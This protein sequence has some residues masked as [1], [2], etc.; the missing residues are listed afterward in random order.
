MESEPL[1]PDMT[2]AEAQKEAVTRSMYFKMIGKHLA[3]TAN[4]LAWGTY[5][6]FKFIPG[7]ADVYA[8]KF[9]VMHEYQ[10]GYPFLVVYMLYVTRQYLNINSSGARAAAA[11][12]RP[13]QHTYEDA[14]GKQV[15]MSSKGAKGRFNRAQRAAFNM[16]ESLPLFASALLG[17]GLVLGPVVLIPA[18]L[19]VYGR[20]NV[21]GS[22]KVDAG[23]RGTGVM[24]AFT[25]EMWTQGLALLCAIKSLA[26]PAIPF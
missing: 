20:I 10:L 2:E 7:Q 16:D 13:D 4:I 14:A 25:G 17:V 15:L 3:I 18:L 12:E 22:Y 8:K 5:L 19:S 9:A 23:A 26:G 6:L 1:T 11:I 21:A 24:L